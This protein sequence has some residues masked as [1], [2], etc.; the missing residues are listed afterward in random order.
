MFGFHYLDSLGYW[1][2]STSFT[3]TYLAHAWLMLWNYDKIFASD[4]T[5]SK[6]GFTVRCVKD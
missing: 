1:W 4:D 6:C 2:T 5:W 3:G